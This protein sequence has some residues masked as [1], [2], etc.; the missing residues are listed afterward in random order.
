MFLA[1]ESNQVDAILQDFPI[2]AYRATKMGTSAVS[3]KF[4]TESEK[5][6]FATSQ[7]NT[8]LVAAI[9]ASLT[10][11]RANGV[12]DGIFQKYFG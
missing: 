3:I 7:E 5:Y 1:L 6:G 9:N 2:N 11:F 8:D 12:Y 4:D 10:E